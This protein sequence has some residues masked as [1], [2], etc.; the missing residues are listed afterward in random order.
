ME[1]C[2]IKRESEGNLDIVRLD[3]S[4]DAFSFPQIDTVLSQLRKESRHRVILD[5]RGLEYVSSAALGALIGFAR[6]AHEQHG[7][8]KLVSVSPKIMATIEL[9]GFHKILD[10]APDVPTAIAIFQD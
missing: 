7:D 2:E 10:M 9:L 5:C 3:G 1:G 6:K 4:L 8:L